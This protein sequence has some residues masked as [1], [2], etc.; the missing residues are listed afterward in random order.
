MGVEREHFFFFLTQCH[1]LAHWACSEFT[2]QA[3]VKRL[4]LWALEH[5]LGLCSTSV[6]QI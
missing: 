1:T 5:Y 2:G 6:C 3:D 4:K